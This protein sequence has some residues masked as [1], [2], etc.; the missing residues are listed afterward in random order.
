LNVVLFCHSLRSDWNHG[1]AHFLRGVVCELMARGHRVRVFEPARGWSAQNLVF[2]AG[3][4]AL[5]A[6]RAVYPDLDIE[7]YELASLDVEAALDAA[8]LV[9]VHEWSPPELVAR[10]GAHRRA[11]GGYRLLFHDTHHRMLT[12]PDEVGGFDLSGYDGVLAF[13]EVLR[14]RYAKLGWGRRA[15]TWHEAA[16]VRVFYPR[17]RLARAGSLV[18]IGN[19]GD[20]ERR[21]EL[22]EFLIEPARS[23]EL[24]TR[25]YGVRYPAEVVCELASAGIEYRGWLPNFAAPEVFA[26]FD[27][28]LHVPRRPYTEVLH[29]IPTIRPFEA[30]AC[31]IPLVCA[32][33]TDSEGLFR[34]GK[35]YLSVSSSAEMRA[36]LSALLADAPRRAELAESGLESIRA[37]H[38]C[39][40]RVDEL[41]G[42]VRGLGSSVPERNHRA[43]VAI[44]RASTQGLS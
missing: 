31:G 21:R 11:H 40:H 6:Y 4:Q 35:D 17:P 32:P 22:A 36:T 38:T 28:T 44:T 14:E 33:W 39:G 13:G 23:L 18:W 20:E 26:Q 25:V 42:I 16:D 9:L 19:F 8:S 2:D 7:P 41:L 29:G 15:F 1:N 30:L 34:A 24:D 43:P 12:A 5:T 27:V 10:I 37:R 3:D